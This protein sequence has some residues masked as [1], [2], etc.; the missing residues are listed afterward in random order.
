MAS[1]GRWERGE[2]EETG[3]WLKG[4]GQMV[5]ATK[6]SKVRERASYLRG[7]GEGLNGCIV[8]QDDDAVGVVGADLEAPT[9]ARRACKLL[10]CCCTV[11]T[12]LLQCCHNVVTIF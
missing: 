6:R 12:M 7:A 9:H 1:E 10:Q 5:G 3:T 2:G 11:V 4:G 8:V